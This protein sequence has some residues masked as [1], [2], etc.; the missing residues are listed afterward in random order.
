ARLPAGGQATPKTYSIGGKQYVVIM[1]GG[2]VSFGT[3]MGDNLFAY[4]L[5]DN[6]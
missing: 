6:L 3:K 5:P 1:A 2:H 4:G